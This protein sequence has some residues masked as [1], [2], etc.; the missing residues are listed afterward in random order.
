MVVP[1]PPVDISLKP[2]GR[3]AARWR[4]WPNCCSPRCWMATWSWGM[5]LAAPGR[6]RW[7]FL[8]CTRHYGFFWKLE[9]LSRNSGFFLGGSINGGI[10]NGWFIMENIVNVDDLGV[11]LFQE[12]TMWTYMIFQDH[13]PIWISMG[14]LQDYSHSQFFLRKIGPWWAMFGRHVPFNFYVLCFGKAVRSRAVGYQVNQRIKCHV[15]K[16]TIVIHPQIYRNWM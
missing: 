16:V 3:W 5:P 13:Y 10:Q 2:T 12:T 7:F 1:H 15:G 8:G 14:R 11:P 6:A 9:D 4:M